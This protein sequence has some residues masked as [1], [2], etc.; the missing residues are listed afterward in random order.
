MA[1]LFVAPQFWR[2]CGDQESLAA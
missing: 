1:F 2:E